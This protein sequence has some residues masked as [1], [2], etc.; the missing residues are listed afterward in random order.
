M[1]RS[2]SWRL[3]AI[4]ALITLLVSLLRLVGEL[5]GWSEVFFRSGAGG[6]GALIG[7]AWLAPVFGIYF[8]LKLQREGHEPPRP[9]RIALWAILG[10]VAFITLGSVP[11]VLGFPFPAE[12]L[13]MGLA[14]I[15]GIVVSARGWPVLGKTLALYGVAARLPVVIIMAF[16]FVGSWGTHYDAPPPGFPETG[17]LARFVLTGV[18]PQL[19]LWV[20]YTIVT[21]ALFGALALKIAVRKQVEP[22]IAA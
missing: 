6:F 4:P 14:G 16:A 20:A 2:T 12:Y 9:V 5:N 1:L 21:G 7:I 3:I 11:V 10:L 15:A 13:V 19:T 8:A 18:L 17:L 22:Q